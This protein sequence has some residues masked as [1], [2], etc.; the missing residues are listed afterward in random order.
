MAGI[1]GASQVLNR[2]STDGL[3][4][5]GQQVRLGRHSG[6]TNNKKVQ[7]TLAIF[8]VSIQISIQYTYIS[9]HQVQ[10]CCF[11]QRHKILPTTT[12][13]VYNFLATIHILI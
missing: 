2:R 10:I 13:I 6:H 8:A 1:L 5:I 4:M 3:A 12:S 7:L 9:S 11:L